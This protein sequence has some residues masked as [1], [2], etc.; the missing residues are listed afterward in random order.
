M[1]MDAKARL[2]SKLECLQEARTD[3]VKMYT[4]R[5]NGCSRPAYHG[6]NNGYC[7]DKCRKTTCLL[8]PEC[9]KP[10]WNGKQDEFCS[11][12]CRKIGFDLTKQSSRITD[13]PP[14]AK[15]SR[16]GESLASRVGQACGDVQLASAE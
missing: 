6:E 16:G 3:V 8:R 15:P 2:Q 9:S 13:R 7:S 12:A 14:Q 10:T 4:C 11:K 5:Q 1:T